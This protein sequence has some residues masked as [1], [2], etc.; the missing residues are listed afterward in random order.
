[1]SSLLATAVLSAASLLPTPLPLPLP[2]EPGGPSGQSAQP[3]TVAVTGTLDAADGRLKRGCKDYAY[4]YTVT[5]GTDDWTFDITLQDRN[6]K[7]VN[8][9]SLI[10]PND[11]ES[12]MLPYRLCRWA[13]K[14]GR[15]TLN[16]VLTSY[17]D[18]AQETEVRVTETFTL[19]RR[20]R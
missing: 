11:A 1:M 13:T 9:Q 10:G 19:R 20:N 3:T 4:A 5:P 8:A 15:F 17:G 6:G 12:G 2:L 18:T 16:G 14:P 7:G